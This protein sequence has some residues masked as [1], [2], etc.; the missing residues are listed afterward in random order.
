MLRGLFSRRR[1]KHE[2]LEEEVEV[3]FK[4]KL[5][6]ERELG[7]TFVRP[8]G[9]NYSSP[10]LAPVPSLNEDERVGG[11][12]GVLGLA[13]EHIPTPGAPISW[14]AAI[15]AAR[16]AKLMGTTGAP[17]STASSTQRKRQHYTKPKKQAS[18]A[19]TRPPRALLCL[20][21]KNPIRRA[22]ISIVEWKPF[23]III[24]MT[25]FANCV[26]LA[27]YIPFPEDDSNATNSNLER[28]EYLF[29]I[30]F[31]VEAFLKVIAY[32]LLCHP[33]AYL[34]NGWNLLDF[35]IVVV[36][37]FSA[38]LEQ[39]TKGDGGTSMGGKAAGF[40]VK[41][42]RAFRVLRPLRLVSGVPSLQVV[43][44]SII[45]A[46]VPL[47]HI[48]LLVLFVI[49]IYAI[50]G[51][52]LFMGKMHRTCFFFKDGHKGTVSEEKPAPC[53][54]NSAHGRHCT[55]ANVTQCL[56][57]W[58]GP[59][60]GI[61]NFDNFAFAM[62]TVFQ[63]ITM[64]GWTDVLYWV[65][66]AVG[67][68][69]PWLYF[70]TLIIIG[71]FFVLNLVL[72]VL[73]GEFS[74]EREK[75]KA[76]GDFQKLRE[77][78]QLEEDLKGYL[79][80][81]TQAE[82]IDPENDDEGLDD[83]KPRNLSMPASE[84]ESVNT[85]NAPAGDMEGETCCTRMANRIS[86]SKFSRYSRRWNRLCRRT[87]RAAVKSNV[88]YWLVIFLV[89]L[90]TL[91]IAS[92]HHQQPQWLTNVQEIAN[93][94]LLAL[95]TGEMLLKMY[96]LGLQA[97]FVSLFNRFDSF[98]VCG[99]ILETILVEI[100]IM[101]PLGISVLRCVRLLRIFKITRYWN[102]LSNL[103]ASL[104][105]SVRSIA[106]LLLL[107]FL[108]IIIFSLLGMQLFGGKFNFDET[109]R[110]TF[111]NFPQSLLTVFQILTGE[112]WNSVMYD[113]IMAYGGPSFPGMLV[114]IYFIILF[115]CGNYILLNVF[116][117]IAV[118]NL[119]DAESL[120]SAQKEEE[121]EKERKKLA[122]TA[123]PEKR[124]DSEKPPLEDE[125]KEEKIELKS[126]TSDGET[127]TATKINIDEYTGDE[128]EEKNPYPVND[129]P[130][131]ED[132]EEPEMPVGPRP[133][134]LSDIQLKEKAVPMPEAKAFFIFSP[135][136]K[137][138][139]LCHKIVNHN[140]FTNLI[141]FFILLSSISLAAE[142]P[143]NNDSFRNQ[144]LGYAD[145][146]FTGIF[147][148]EIILKMT[149]YG[150]FLHKGSFCR[151]YFNILDL[152]VVSVSLISS[153]IQS[154]AINVVKIL[155]VLRVLRPLR[156]INRAKGLKHVVQCVFVAIR[157]IG[158]IVIVTTL[159]QFM[160]ACIGV[161]LFKGKFFYCTD[162]SKQTQAECRGSYI[163]YKDG[164]VGK[165]EKAQRSWENSDFNFDDV[166]Q[167]MMALF[168]VSTFEGWPGLLYRAID[169]HAEDIGPIYNYRVIISIF[170][171]IYIIIIAFFMMNIFVGFVIVTFQ[172]QGEQ[173]YKNCELDK[174]QRQ[175]VEYAL[176]ARPLRRYIPKN[177]YQYK[178]WY[179]VNST[180][181]EYLMFTLILLNTI[182]LAMQ[183]HGQSQSFSKAM[184]ILNMLFTGLFTVEMILKLIAFKPRHY[185]VDAWNTFDALIV[186]GSV[187][188]IAIT[189]VNGLQNTEDNARI[190][191][192]FFRLFRV[193]RLV[194]LLSRGEGIRTLLWTFIK[195]FQALPYVA[196]L[197]VMLFF[198]YAVIG[199][200]MFGKIALR[201]HSQ[202][203]R[204]NN[205]QTF[206]QA[207]LLLFRCATGEAWQEIMLACSPNRPCEKGTEVG[208]SSED[209]GSHFA[210]IYFVS[211]YMLCAFLIINLFVAVIMDNFDYL[212]RDW[213]ILGP[214]HLDEFKRIWAEYDP[215]AKG[216][217]KHLDVV[218]LLRRIQPPL[219]FG[220][221]C[222][223]RVACK[224]L[225]SMN[226]PLNS[227]GTV[228]FNATLFA[229]VRTALRIKTE[230]NL[231]QAN[232][233]LRAIVKKIWKRTSMKL[234]DQ[235]VPPAGDDEVTVGKFYATFLIQ[236]YFRKFKKRK[237]QG[238]VAKI[239]PKT[240]LSLQAGLRTLHDMGPEIRRAIS[241]DLTVEEELERAMKETVCTASEDD[242]FR[243]K[244]SGGLFGN[245][246]NYYHQS[247]GHAS[248]PQSFTTQ[249]PLH[250]SKSGSPGEAESPS[251]Q[252]LVDS[253]FTPSS[254]SSSGSNANINN[255][256]NTAI[257]HRYP[258]P[259]VST[260]D[261]QTGPPLTTV[262]LPRPT[263]CFPNKRSCFYDTFMRSDSSDSRLP[264]IRRE[265]AS[266][267]ETYDET[268]LDERDQTMLS[269]DMLEFQDEESKQLAPMVEADVGE[270]RRPWQSPR[271]RA[272]LCPTALG[273][274]SSFHLE[275]LRKHN[276]PDVSQK[277][278]LPLHLVHHQALAVAGLSPLLRRS[279]SPT[280]F[281][282]LCSTPP[283]SP[284]GR[285][286]GGPCYQPVP[287][288]RL[289]GSGSYE[290]LN[291]SMP[292][293]NCSSWYSDSNGNH[294]R[295]VQRTQRPVSLTVPPV[296]RRDSTS[297]SHGSAGSLVEAVL[298]SEGLGRYAQDPTFIQV[299]KQELADACDMTMEEMEN[300]ADNIL[301]ANAPPN[302][303]GN[304]LPF[305]QCRDTGS[306]ESRCSHALGLSTAT[307]SDELLGAELECS[308]GAGQRNST[309]LEDE[310]ME[311]VTSL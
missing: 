60:D 51:L 176:K 307:G 73:S 78:Q 68:S 14:Q 92:E 99:G 79:D 159:L 119:A 102:S 214:H 26:A 255:A 194:K 272:F 66:D 5:V 8:G 206:P 195:S 54:P 306:Q 297:L 234:L 269:M 118:D 152:V 171:I 50:I 224:R 242:I 289:E 236:E 273:R 270:E 201:D 243:V 4:G 2:R 286:G 111:D 295:S 143:V 281:T 10:S 128:N 173:E 299:A 204:N 41:A 284:S 240:A 30:I 32:G 34:R 216:R 96:S 6:S 258:K 165:P 219:G 232:E 229:L 250:I 89:F 137:F 282:R 228:M 22:C 162:T 277:T 308:E 170:F 174:N 58:E 97:Y 267:D 84:N 237:E 178:V 23:E 182:C 65:N 238:L 301:N 106:S 1:L 24:L 139:V 192:T 13:P 288:L 131:E 53:A 177:P 109:R 67:S 151:N 257:G 94:V 117:A 278:A 69:W 74:K 37:L 107:L 134:P 213:S 49:I 59:N 101:S 311:C 86:K 124:Q 33:N 61:T 296:T 126:I 103:V 210:I 52:E 175:C 261:G 145:Y 247:D 200:Q 132:D 260:V 203:N 146:V 168:A 95:F 156:A 20:T 279:H 185:F 12:G 29:L 141:L 245:H 263:W 249:R 253:T 16:Q 189:E 287:S 207:V 77:K 88:F 275:C 271:R 293:V 211:F 27:V 251:H 62:L 113:G 298:I 285:G 56:M 144:I 18:T 127:P 7:Y 231:E 209:C 225:V 120:T 17:I 21:L 64:E 112:D 150:A 133:R 290:K 125:K 190:S 63:C 256:N 254:Y 227:D 116:L 223:H 262:P 25:I 147:T 208:H 248:F 166:L 280:L 71:S 11:G 153:G 104:L 135:S 179:V 276:R 38:I 241:G 36:G 57:G 183:H 45:K 222:P 19:S 87:C 191:I 205:F 110:S 157:T 90:N 180:Y 163:L 305:I 9:S 76:R 220:K 184:N 44:N 81:I 42:L 85:D 80:W 75:A 160:F 35:I 259:T 140:I 108:F 167:G 28:V 55:P 291:S 186:V 15:D 193:M 154:S 172:E 310:D 199:M 72:G 149:A 43:L 123:S 105:N 264:I 268:F 212:T 121:E 100:K 252:K 98:V 221:L 70:V 129:F 198:I 265:E 164:N 115:I 169:S 39:A 218:T 142:D 300:A 292:S 46:M 217:I 181:F 266:T 188:D 83:D 136:N 226:M 130:G 283:A 303:N 233:E 158:N 187:V 215:E 40:D 304:L 230:G 196:L 244:R 114:C 91:T 239:P 246:V 197:I 82:D 122:R 31:T 202:I 294:S 302:A 47:L 148:I 155:R 48:A 235:V 138:R 309:L 93:K 161:Q 3:R 274:R